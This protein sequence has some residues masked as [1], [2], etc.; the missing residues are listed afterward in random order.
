MQSALT[1]VIPI[2]NYTLLD[3]LAV[4][5][6]CTVF[7]DPPRLISYRNY[8]NWG[9]IGLVDKLNVSFFKA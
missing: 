6:I 1:I 2:I 9:Y 8:Y 5:M 7:G 4:L 3:R